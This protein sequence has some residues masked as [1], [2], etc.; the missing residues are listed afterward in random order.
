MVPNFIPSSQYPDDWYQGSVSFDDTVWIID[1]EI[2][3][4]SIIVDPNTY[5]EPSVDGINLILS[6]DEN[7][8]IFTNKKITPCGE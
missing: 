5:S 1:T 8:L 4:G 6:E 2:N 3:L 7:Y